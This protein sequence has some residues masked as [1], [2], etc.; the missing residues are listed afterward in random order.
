MPV[1]GPR[2]KVEKIKGGIAEGFFFKLTH[3]ILTSASSKG[4]AFPSSHCAVAGIVVLCAA[5]FDLITFAVLCPL[6]AG[7]V[8]GTVYARF[9]YAVDAVTGTVLAGVVF[10]FTPYLYRFLS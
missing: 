10:G 7:L 5:R 6:G 9:H 2:Y 4:T 8:I 3:A 1:T